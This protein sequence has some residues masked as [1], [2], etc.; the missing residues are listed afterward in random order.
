MPGFNLTIDASVTAGGVCNPGC[1]WPPDIASMLC[2]RSLDCVSKKVVGI[3]P[4]L[5]EIGDP[6]SVLA[7]DTTSMLSMRSLV[8]GSRK[9]VGINPGAE[10][11]NTDGSDCRSTDSIWLICCGV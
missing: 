9:V 8:C 11:K 2:K 4:G 7:L 3:K 10:N 1:E 6:E 5:C